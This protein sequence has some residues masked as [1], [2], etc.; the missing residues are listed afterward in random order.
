M[1]TT[2]RLP[3]DLHAQL[4]SLAR[5]ERRSLSDVVVQ[6]LRQSLATERPMGLTTSRDGRR[7]TTGGPPITADDVRSLD[8]ED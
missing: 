7:I 8:D 1:R 4:T 6:V 3:D 2:I 5:D